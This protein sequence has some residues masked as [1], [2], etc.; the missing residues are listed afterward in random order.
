LL[1]DDGTADHVPHLAFYFHD[2][3]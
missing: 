2:L 1:L 3:C